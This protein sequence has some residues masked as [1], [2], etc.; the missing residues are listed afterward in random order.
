MQSLRLFRE[1]LRQVAESNQHE[2]SAQLA[3]TLVD[4]RN[5]FES[6]RREALSKWNEELDAGGVR[7][8]HAAAES[9]GRSS[10]WFQQEA[11]ARMQVLV[12]QTLAT[13]TSTFDEKTAEAARQFETKLSEQSAGRI[14]Q[15]HQE[16]DGV[17]NELSGRAR[18]EMAVAAE[19]AAASF[20]QVL[21]G[22][23]EQRSRAVHHQQPRD[24]CR[25]RAGVRAVCR[26][27]HAKPR[28][29]RFRIG[30][31]FPG[32]DGLPNRDVGRGRPQRARLGIRLDARKLPRRSRCLQKRMGG[33]P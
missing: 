2:A 22:I 18:T 3:S 26:R 24:P 28:V 1:R 15:I 33:R 14:A 7:A 32:A 21:H 11:R 6:A 19:A 20:G 16:L 10:E 12:E 23:S 29:Q 4:L 8:S 5:D 17:A 30:E 9:I 25:A 27:R 31:S 13:A